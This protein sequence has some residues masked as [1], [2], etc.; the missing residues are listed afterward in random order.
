[1]SGAGPRYQLSARS[2]GT[3]FFGLTVAQLALTA[4]GVVVAIKT[5]TGGPPDIARI[6]VAATVLVLAVAVS[7]GSWRSRPIYQA[8]PT[9]VRVAWGLLRGSDRWFC[10]LPLL[11]SDGTPQTVVKPPRCLEG[12]EVLSVDRPAWAGASRTLAPVG[13]VRDS[14]SGTVTAVLSIKGK[15]FQ[16]MDETDQHGRIFAWGRVLAQ[17]A[18]ESSPVARICW[19]EW[20]CPAPLA[21][22]LTWLAANVDEDATA[23]PHYRRMLADQAVSVAR[24]ELRVTITV[25][26]RRVGRGRVRPG[27]MRRD[28]ADVALTMLRS[29][30]DRCRDAGL[31]VSDPLSPAALNDAVRA[32]G[33]PSVLSVADR[34]GSLEM[35]AGLVPMT[36][37]MPLAM[38]AAWDHVRVDGAFHRSFWVSRWPTLEVGP[39]W[40]E[41]LLLDTTG[42]RTVTMV[43]EP[44]SPRT[45]RRRINHDAVR[46][47]GDVHNRARHDFRIPVE[48]QRAQA[49]LDRR[50]AELSAGFAEYM[51][52]ALVSV[53]A[54]DL[55]A[56]DELSHALVDVAAGCG[57]DL[58]QLD[59]RHDAAWACSLPIGRSPDRDLVASIAG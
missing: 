43:M 25:D 11:A 51:Y 8:V 46:V 36:T 49:D 14:R 7:F 38:Q 52:L 3:A 26:P 6:V 48:L 57:L 44:V 54:S 23:T 24:H 53:T 4:C 27:R 33:D 1:M 55:E 37:A 2:T 47:Q 39:R 13:L 16:L 58:R 34:R 29:L 10:R 19:H 28:T 9:V 30:A 56:L 22:H 17:F 31:V 15:E 50:E 42:T 32:C 40:L 35:R 59:G 18:R 45:S 20:S 21:D 12:I 41:P 5:V